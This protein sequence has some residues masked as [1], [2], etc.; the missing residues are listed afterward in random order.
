MGRDYCLGAFVSRQAAK[1]SDNST[2]E[3]WRQ[4]VLGLLD[5]DCEHCR[6]HLV[7]IEG[8]RSFTEYV[9][10]YLVKAHHDRDVEKRLLAVT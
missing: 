4:T 2:Q 7:W 10:P 6:Q 5:G 1:R 8:V 9:L 3:M